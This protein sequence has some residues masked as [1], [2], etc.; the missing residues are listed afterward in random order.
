MQRSLRRGALPTAKESC[1]LNNKD[2]VDIPSF[3]MFTDEPGGGRMVRCSK[4]LYSVQGVVNKFMVK[5][6]DLVAFKAEVEKRRLKAKQK[7]DESQA[8][9]KPQKKRSKKE[10]TYFF[11]GDMKRLASSFGNTM[12]CG[13]VTMTD[14]SYRLLNPGTGCV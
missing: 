2:L 4:E 9:D 6:C 8:S 12:V 14:P 7:Y 1:L 11:D 5:Y 10:D 13:L 3:E